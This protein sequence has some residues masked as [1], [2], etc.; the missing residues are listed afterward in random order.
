MY[1]LFYFFILVFLSCS[2]TK[3]GLIVINEGYGINSIINTNSTKEKIDSIYTTSDLCKVIIGDFKKINDSYFVDNR[4]FVLKKTKD[5]RCYKKIGVSIVFDDNSVNEIIFNSN[6]FITKKGI[7]IGDN[8]KKVY[9]K[10]GLNFRES[11]FEYPSNKRNKLTMNDL[12]LPVDYYD[13]IGIGFV[14]NKNKKVKYIIV[15]KKELN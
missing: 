10:Y 8:Q 14:Y 6:K 1:R 9:K 13:K 3:T 2:S 4:R 7:K 5:K 15:F 12:G 11:F